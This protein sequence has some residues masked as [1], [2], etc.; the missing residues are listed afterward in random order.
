M[1]KPQVLNVD[2]YLRKVR[3]TFAKEGTPL[4]G[5]MTIKLVEAMAAEADKL[6]AK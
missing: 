4:T 5:T 2:D 6:S 1:S 3:E